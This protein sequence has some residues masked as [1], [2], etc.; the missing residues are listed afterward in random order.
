M[1]K[2]ERLG[3]E[4]EEYLR[5]LGVNLA[6]A[7]KKKGVSQLALA[8]DSGVARSYI[9]DLERGKRNPTLLTLRK[10]CKPL[11]IEPRSLLPRQKGEIA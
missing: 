1:D 6:K 3:Y 2:D 8:L 9:A 10:V 5:V 4:D 11:G 7:R